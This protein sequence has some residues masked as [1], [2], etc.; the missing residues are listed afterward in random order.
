MRLCLL[1]VVVEGFPL[2]VA[3]HEGALDTSETRGQVMLGS[4]PPNNSE[5]LGS[6]LNT[7]YFRSIR[8]QIP[9]ISSTRL[10]HVARTRGQ[11]SYSSRFLLPGLL[12][13]EQKTK[14]DTDTGFSSCLASCCKNKRPSK[15]LFQVFPWVTSCCENKRPSKIVTLVSLPAN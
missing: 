9:L 13:R 3:T 10:P 5:S 1:V 7:P 14:Q 12:L 11:A 15:L 8:G 2:C 6:W 4:S